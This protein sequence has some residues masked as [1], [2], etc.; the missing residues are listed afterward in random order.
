MSANAIDLL[1][2]RLSGENYKTC[3]FCQN[4]KIF[5]LALLQPELDIKPF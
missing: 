2:P 1:G 3:T 4:G 5:M